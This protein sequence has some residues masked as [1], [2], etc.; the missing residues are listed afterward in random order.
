M[1]TPLNLSKST[2]SFTN[3]TNIISSDSMDKI[4][5]HLKLHYDKDHLKK[6]LKR[7]V[8]KFM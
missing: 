1:L 4:F 8:I 7:E 6:S 3:H 5:G 2:F